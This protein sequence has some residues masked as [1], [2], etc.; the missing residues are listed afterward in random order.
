M[1]TILVENTK[2]FNIK[3]PASLPAGY[4]VA[5]M[6]REPASEALELRVFETYARTF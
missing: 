5:A 2:V 6:D 4:Y 3:L 1:R